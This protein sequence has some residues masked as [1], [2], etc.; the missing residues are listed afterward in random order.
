ML[1]YVEYIV[2]VAVVVFLSIK[3]S[4]YVDLLD[5]KT[6]LSGAF[7]GGIMLSAV[8]SL[9]EL[10][11]S[12]SSV[13]LVGKAGMCL[14]NVLGSDLF[15]LAALSAVILIFFRGFNKGVFSPSNRNVGLAVLAIY[16]I[17]ELNF[18]GVCD[19]SFLSI[20][21]T[22]VFII[23]MYALGVKYLSAAS[24]AISDEE[25]L[26]IQASK[27]SSLTVKQ[28]GIR[29]FF[30]AVGIIVSSILLTYF[31]DGIAVKLGIGT[32]FAGA[33]FLGIATSLP[34]VTSTVSLFKMKNY[35]IAIGNIIGSNLF[36][37][38]ILAI[39][40]IISLSQNIYADPDM[41]VKSLTICGLIATPMFYIMMRTK[42]K[43]VRGICAVV[44]LGSYFAFLMI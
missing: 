12:L 29:F 43:A 14:G 9:P 13:F 34:E 35:N 30:T 31:T 8:T 15:N 26:D 38:I 44:M 20:S 32:G 37:F 39:V 18:I 41:Q 6:N 17:I 7:L 22:T 36:N 19:I 3:A 11:T 10:L 42:K 24:D 27:T 4:D 23:V 5:K 2:T 28:I 21:F 33:L 16:I 25:E 40:D 1:I